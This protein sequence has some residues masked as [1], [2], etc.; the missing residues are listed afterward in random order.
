MVQAAG[1]KAGQGGKARGIGWAEEQSQTLTAEAGGNGVPSVCAIYDARGNGDGKTASTITGD[2]ENRV[3]DY[4]T[5]VCVQGNVIDR[6]ENAKCNGIGWREDISY[7]LNTIDRQAVSYAIATGQANAEIMENKAPTL[8]C[9]H[10]EPI[11]VN[12]STLRK[13]YIVRRL[14]ETECARLQGFPDWWGDVTPLDTGNPEEVAFWRGVY[15]TYCKINGKKSKK[16][17]LED[18]GKLA[19][20]HEKLHTPSAE[21]KMWGNGIALPNAL[22]VMQGISD[23]LREEANESRSD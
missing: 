1:F 20:W 13:R 12:L 16:T 17:I 2:H 15:Q 19:E 9:N 8:N 21:Y 3:T 5:V 18:K 22:Y 14:T 4:T 11:I 7:T 10:E 6:P 23:A